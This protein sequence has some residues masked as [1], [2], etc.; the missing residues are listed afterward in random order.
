MNNIECEHKVEESNDDINIDNFME[1]LRECQEA[2]KQAERWDQFRTTTSFPEMLICTRDFKFMDFLSDYLKKAISTAE[3]KG[4][5][6][7]CLRR[8]ESNDLQ[9]FLRMVCYSEN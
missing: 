9:G 4:C 5:C 2:A 1:A 6:A 3:Q 8:F 7:L